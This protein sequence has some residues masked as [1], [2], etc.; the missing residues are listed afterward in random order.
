[1]VTEHTIQQADRRSRAILKAIVLGGR[2]GE[3]ASLPAG[4]APDSLFASTGALVPPYDP[5]AL[6]MLMEHSNSLSVKT[7]TLTR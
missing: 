5:E 4:E 1:M 2:T 3:P 7:L 6:C